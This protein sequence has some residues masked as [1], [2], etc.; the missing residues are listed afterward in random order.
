M[1]CCMV[2]LY[3]GKQ[4]DLTGFSSETG[5]TGKLLAI[6][7]H[8]NDFF[9]SICSLCPRLSGGK[10]EETRAVTFYYYVLC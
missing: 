9:F 8:F 4:A 5:K 3:F 7:S 1:L 10:G 2:L 6:I